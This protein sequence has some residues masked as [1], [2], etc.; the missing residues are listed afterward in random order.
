MAHTLSEENYLKVIYNLGKQGNEKISPTAIAQALTNNPASV[1]DMLKKL[2]DKKLLH[3]EKSRGVKLTD[4]GKKTALSIIRNHRLWE[5]FLFENLAYTWDEVHAIAEQL[6]H[7]HH[8]ELAD[9]LDKFLGF[10]PYDPHGDPIPKSNGEMP[11]LSSFTLLDVDSGKICKVVG[12]RDTSVSFLKYLQKLNIGIGTSIRMVDKIEFDGSM[13][14]HIEKGTPVSVSKKFAESLLVKFCLLLSLGCLFFGGPAVNAQI[15]TTIAGD[16]V[17]GYNGDNIL[18]NQAELAS[19]QSLATDTSGDIYI[20]DFDNNRIRKITKST[21]LLTT[22]AGTGVGGYSGDGGPAVAAELNSPV[23]LAIDLSGNL[24][25]SD[26]SNNR[27]RKVDAG[28]G[29]ITTV[30]GNGLF[31]YSG[32]RGLATDATFRSPYGISLDSYGNLFIADNEN[33]VI[34]KVTAGTGKITTVAGDSIAGYNGDDSAAI[35]SQLNYPTGVVSD[36]FGNIYIAD[37]GNNRI[38]RVDAITGIISTVAGN[39]SA[40]YSGDSSAALSA[41]LNMPYAVALD[42]NNNLYIIDNINNVIRKVI[43]ASGIIIT[44]AGNGTSGYSG[45]DLPATLA[46]LNLPSGIA[47]D[48]AGN[49]YIADA[50][51][52]RVREVNNIVSS[53]KE[54]SAGTRDV[55]IFPNPCGDYFIVSLAPGL[56]GEHPILE[57]FDINGK[58]IQRQLLQQDKMIIDTSH[59]GNGFYSLLITTG[60]AVSVKRLVIV[61]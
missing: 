37:W 61:R 60:E 58:S 51:N 49:L 12:V 33:N 48:P 40:G 13:N 6:E 9:R 3:Y 28:S 54:L 42:K 47:F 17:Q 11:S 35:V 1:I 57:V 55:G 5:V 39:G 7:V 41:Q 46:Q 16:S 53:L 24:Y 43:N 50:G 30:A 14:I 26:L 21:G 38:R 59:L 34:R 32:D 27:I 44:I 23:A 19:P 22:V 45:D 52:N 8:A 56:S 18:A 36:A 15:I 2:G 4:K 20:A 29:I 10:P 25:I 31:G